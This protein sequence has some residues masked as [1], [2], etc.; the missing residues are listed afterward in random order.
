MNLGNVLLPQDELSK[1]KDDHRKIRVR[2][3]TYR[4]VKELV[5]PAS[6]GMKCDAIAH[7]LTRSSHSVRQKAF[8]LNVTLA[9]ETETGPAKAH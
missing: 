7:I 5:R 2:S 4:E 9:N 6:I 8:W 1:M 3:W